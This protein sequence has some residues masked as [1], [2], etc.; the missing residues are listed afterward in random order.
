ML[1]FSTPISFWNRYPFSS[2]KMR[3][4]LSKVLALLS[5][6]IIISN[7]QAQSLLIDPTAEGGFELGNGSFSA[8]GWTVVNGNN[9][10]WQSS[11]V[12][13]P[14]AGTNHAFIS[15]DGGA[16]YGY[17]I[18]TAATSH[19]Y[20]DV[21][22][23]AGQSIISLNFQKKNIGESGWDRLLV[24]T[25][26]TTV[27][28]VSCIPV[29]N[30]T[31]LTGAN[32]VY[33]DPASTAA[34]TSVTVALPSSLAGT[35]FRLIFTWQSDNQF[36]TSPGAAVDNISLTSGLPTLYTSTASGGSWSQPAT[37]IGGVVPA[38][39]ND[40]LIRNGSTV[41]I[42]QAVNVRDLTVG[43]GSSGILQWGTA[44][45]ALT[46]SRN[47]VIAS[48]GQMHAH[49]LGG[50]GQVVTIG[51]NYTNNGFA[52]HAFAS[53]QITFNGASGSTLGGTGT[54]LGNGTKGIIRSL[55]FN[56]LGAGVISTTQNLFLTAGLTHTAG[57]LSTNGKLAIDN[58]TAV[59]GQAINQQVI[60]I[61]MTNLG[62]GYTS[63]PTVMLSAPSFG[64]TATATANFDA[65]SGTV[66]S[67][68]ITN[69]GSGYCTNPNVTFSGGGSFTTAASA[70][71]VVISNISGPANS[72]VQ[73]SANA[74]VIGA[75]TINS[76]QRVGSVTVTNGGVGYTSAPTVGFSL[77]TN[78]NLVTN[79]C[80][81]G[82]TAVPTVTAIGG[83]GTGA[84]FTTTVANGK[85]TSIYVNSGG[86][87]YTS[88]PAI[89]IVGG[90]GAG[91]MAAM[92]GG[93]VARA[94]A[95]ISNQKVTGFIVTIPGSGYVAA[96]TV[97]LTGGGFSTAASGPS[98]RIGLYNLTLG[99][100][101]PSIN[102]IAHSVDALYPSNRRLNQLT[103]NSSGSP[104]TLTGGTW[105]IYGSNTPLTLTS[106]NIN[107]NGSMLLF[108]FQTYAGT[109][110]GAFSFVTNGRVS[111]TSP[112]GS[113]TRNFPL[114]TQF[115]AFT[116]TG[117]LSTGSN[118]TSLTCRTTTAPSGSVTPSGSPKGTKAFRL[119]TTGACFAAPVYGTAPTV[120][121]FYNGT[122][123]IVSDNPSLIIGQSANLNGPY[124]VR[125]VT[126]GTGALPATG[127]RTTATGAPGPINLPGDSYFAWT[128]TLV[129]VPM[130]YEVT[131][132]TGVGYN[133]ISS[134]CIVMVAS[135]SN[136]GT[137]I[138]VASTAG[139]NAGD[140]IS[141]VSNGTGAFAANTVVASI[142]SATQ[143]TINIAPTSS[144]SFGTRIL[145]C[146][147]GTRNAISGI[148]TDDASSVISLVG[149]TFWY[150]GSTPT[151]MTV[152][153]N[154]YIT[155]NG[156]AISG[157]VGNNTMAGCTRTIAPF[158]EDLT[159]PGHTLPGAISPWCFYQISGGALG[160]GSAV[161]KVQWTAM[162]T[163]QNFGSDI[164]FQ[165]TLFEDGR[166][167]FNYGKMI[168]FDGTT[169]TNGAYVYSYTIGMSNNFVNTTNPTLGQVL[170]QQA[171]NTPN[172]SPFFTSS[173]SRGANYLSTLPECNSSLMFTPGAYSNYLPGPS[174]PSNDEPINAIQLIST[175]NPQSDLCFSYYSTK[176]ATQTILPN[177]AACGNPLYSNND[178]DVWF[179]FQCTDDSTKIRVASSGGFDAKV[180]VYADATAG[181][182]SGTPGTLVACNDATLEGLLENFEVINLVVGHWYYAR[183]FHRHG[184]VKATATPVISNGVITSI[185][186]NNTGSGYM[187]GAYGGTLTA[188]PKVY[189]TGG[190]GRNAVAQTITPGTNAN[191]C[192]ITS[193]AVLNGGSGYGLG[194]QVTVEKPNWGI[195]GDFAIYLLESTASCFSTIDQADR[196]GLISDGPPLVVYP[197]PTNGTLK[198]SLINDDSP[199]LVVFPNPSNGT[200]T[201]QAPFSGQI[202]IKNELGQ[203]IRSI[204][205]SENNFASCDVSG[206]SAG[207]YF[208]SGEFNGKYYTEK[209]IITH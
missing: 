109:A 186:V 164:N 184:G 124:T 104:V 198:N 2:I 108:T 114:A 106:G 35:T 79:N 172:F 112:G 101:L 185:T 207:L 95:T 4:F 107:I 99:W 15:N 150:S 205:L 188:S 96:P 134:G 55:N 162:E 166:I 176:G 71:A 91:A 127:S 11:G 113:V 122:D 148:S 208:I 30:S 190:S 145:A 97:T 136:A 20:R 153:N 170:A 132:I 206:L 159:S 149:T 13:A 24:Y 173:N 182:F 139:L 53:S 34:Y 146:P 141:Y 189:I 169:G 167:E 43:E 51:G 110:P 59:F 23:Q 70:I 157:S 64:T 120:Q 197:N 26:P 80:G 165:V 121:L 191:P 135:G 171:E 156:G 126:T 21:S 17:S 36:G 105:T 140:A 74:T 102:N 138:N 192:G 5:L 42:D 195:S 75:V 117:S 60:E 31:T 6:L 147:N 1:E 77:P 72:L 142:I 201:I 161:I 154:G 48:G 7:T 194:T 199:R 98:C 85:I 63:P 93:S 94:T 163:L 82:Y 12:G 58:T 29:S 125:S 180:E 69:P 116:G 144:L 152:G 27:V 175:A 119:Q 73:R 187:N 14:F 193:I 78:I 179:K 40:I 155:F 92:P 38:S 22:L 68:T 174:T 181:S 57:S 151:S 47:L 18:A 160:S 177:P 83:G 183:I 44:S 76:S 87:G 130:S 204:K 103:M 115:T 203:I 86:T 37:W 66:R 28:P 10:T 16:T 52:N 123:A 8:N 88:E 67:I 46:V 202:Y 45:S 129:F 89:T 84:T 50:I 3:P 133:D 158:W 49:T 168:G 19:F 54:F 90:G 61:V 178:D 143:F 56:S 200:F 131:R 118:I 33:T 41:V 128:S 81:S 39:G 196:N 111:L 62:A 100:F 9:N 209:V 65:A 32:L 25:A 137:T